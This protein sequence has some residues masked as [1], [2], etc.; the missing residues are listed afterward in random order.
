MLS[1]LYEKT[2]SRFIT[3]VDSRKQVELISSIIAR[4]HSKEEK[5]DE[6]EE[7]VEE[8]KNSSDVNDDDNDGPYV[9]EEVVDVLDE[10]DVLPYRAG[11]EEQ[12]RSRIQ[13]RL[14]H[15]K[16]NGI[17]STSALELGIDIPY[18]ETCVLVGVPPSLTS[19]QQRI[20]RIGRHST[21]NVIVINSGSVYDQ[22]VFSNPESLL[23][24]PLSESA[25]AYFR[26]PIYSV[27]PCTVFGEVRR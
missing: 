11:Y 4:N 15:G 3:F 18:L 24:R 8:A 21:G 23:Q 7:F 20:G 5:D 16:L 17:I 1:P 14:T 9:P 27:Y 22:A 12:D 2:N 6:I 19:L 25:R 10:I 13:E 26:E